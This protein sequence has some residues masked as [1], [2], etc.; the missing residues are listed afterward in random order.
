MTETMEER[1]GKEVRISRSRI[2]VVADELLAKED[3]DMVSVDLVN[4]EEA[5]IGNN[6]TTGQVNTTQIIQTTRTTTTK[7]LIPS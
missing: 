2:G 3:E 6:A 4:E 1:N 5:E 7:E